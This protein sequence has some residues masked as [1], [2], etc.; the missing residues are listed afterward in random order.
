MRKTTFGFALAAAVAAFSLMTP[1]FGDG[2]G[3][4]GMGG[5]GLGG[6]QVGGTTPGLGH[7]GGGGG[8]ST[9]P[10]EGAKE[11][12]PK[13]ILETIAGDPSLS[14]LQAA[15]DGTDVQIVLKGSGPFTLL[16]PNNLAFLDLDPEE[17]TLLLQDKTKLKI[18]LARHVVS[19]RTA[20]ADV[21]K[22]AHLLTTGGASL[23]VKVEADG[24]FTIAG[25]KIVTADVKC[26]NGVIHVVDKVLLPPKKAAK[27]AEKPADEP[28]VGK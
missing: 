18:A 26:S 8:T 1:G 11:E 17:L 16:A 14:K 10:S 21:A 2:A 22:A 27:P 6:G 20:S 28:A 5:G 15:L 12:K 3:G 19:G 24:K 25:A 13:T 9:A 7:H 23:D 4:G